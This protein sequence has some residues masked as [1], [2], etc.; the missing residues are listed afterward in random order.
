M[1]RQLIWRTPKDN[2]FTITKQAL[3]DVAA[4]IRAVNPDVQ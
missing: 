2:K 4:S 3:T 1:Y